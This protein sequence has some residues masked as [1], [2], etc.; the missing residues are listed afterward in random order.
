MMLKRMN[1]VHWED[2]PEQVDKEKS[3]Q[4]YRQW[5]TTHK[6]VVFPEENEVWYGQDFS[7]RQGVPPNIEFKVNTF[8][9]TKNRHR[10]TLTAD[11]YG[12]LNKPDRYG[13]G[14]LYV[15]WEEIK[16]VIC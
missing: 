3:T 14:K 9:S 2:V 12:E 10:M 1:I 5:L 7:F 8:Q 13:N 16:D 4:T 15:N 11:G 6:T